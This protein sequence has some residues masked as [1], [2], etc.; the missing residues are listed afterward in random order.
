MFAPGWYPDYSS[1]ARFCNEKGAFDLAL[2]AAMA[3]LAHNPNDPLLHLRVAQSYDG[4]GNVDGT[5]V[6]CTAA[7]TLD[8]APDIEAQILATLALAYERAGRIDAA[9]ATAQRAINASPEAIEPHVAYGNILAHGGDYATAW[10]ELEFFFLDERAW[11]RRRFSMPEWNGE[12]LPGGRLL[13][14]HGQGAGDLLQMARYLP[15]L[16]ARGIEVALEAPPALAAIMALIEGITIVPKDTVPRELTTAFA[17]AMTLP[18]ILGEMGDTPRDAYLR[19]PADRAEHWRA[20]LGPRTSRMRVGLCWAGNPYHGND[21]SRS[22][23]LPAFAPFAALADIEWISLQVGPRARD[24]AP[25][26]LELVRLDAEIGDFADTAAI[27]ATCEVIIAVDTAV[28]HLAGAIGV[29]VWVLLPSR[30]EW[31][32]PRAGE[33]SPWYAS[34][35]LAHADH[36]GWPTAIAQ[37][38]AWLRETGR[39]GRQGASRTRDQASR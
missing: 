37:A 7:L 28:A 35:R 38:A 22:L 15:E 24:A 20:R 8:P 6:R 11:F 33:R 17:R 23:S 5:I 2:Q 4:A 39:D 27:A 29:P 26:G 31:R 1:I 21:F 3:G 13:V 25:P 9:I 34:M 30:P 18:R 36:D 16:R 10:R 14:V 12:E 19:V 32:W